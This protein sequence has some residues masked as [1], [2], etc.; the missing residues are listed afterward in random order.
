[1][2]GTIIMAAL[3]ALGLGTTVAVAWSAAAFGHPYLDRPAAGVG[4]VRETPTSEWHVGRYEHP[5]GVAWSSIRHRRA[6]SFSSDDRRPEDL[7]R[8]LAPWTGLESPRDGY[9]NRGVRQEVRVVEAYGWP[10]PALWSE[11]LV[12]VDEVYGGLRTGLPRRALTRGGAPMLAV[13]LP[14]R[15]LWTGLVVNTAI[16]TVLWTGP[17][18]A[19][20]EGR[21]GW[22]LVRGRCPGC[23]YDVSR[24][25]HARCP[26]CGA[27]LPG[28][29][30]RRTES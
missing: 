11:H 21:R 30:R 4:A 19:F 23:A 7:I 13:M 3:I 25:D 20:L 1:M 26:E 14:W 8:M 28:R 9:A 18:L 2:R 5:F 10:R 22:R 24:A 12:L 29:R 16:F 6:P 15:P 27:A 17:L